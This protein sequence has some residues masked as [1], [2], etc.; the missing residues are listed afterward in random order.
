MSER[1]L[2]TGGAGFFGQLL[3]ARLLEAGFEVRSLDVV[4]LEPSSPVAEHM[5]E[6]TGDVRDRAAVEQAVAGCEVVVTN[7]AL[8]PVTRAG[9]DFESVNVGGTRVVLE[10]ARRA[11][12]RHATHISSSAV[13]GF[14]SPMPI[15]EATPLA[16]GERYGRSKAAAEQAAAESCGGELPLAI[17]RPRTLVGLGRLGLFEPLFNWVARS[18]PV[19]LIGA[20]GNL[21]QFLDAADL[22]T[23]CLEGIRRKVAGD[24][25]LGSAVYGTL[26]EDIEAVIRHAGSA[27]R[28]RAVP[29]WAA[30]LVLQPLDWA[31]LSPFAPWHYL[32]MHRPFYFDI[33]KAEGE[34]GFQPARSDQEIFVEAYDWHISH[35]GV[36]GASAHR[37]PLRRGLLGLLE[38]RP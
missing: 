38:R 18:R 26:R 16:P 9:R 33:G 31:R 32:G 28:I 35:E 17:L 21:F 2:I 1:V 15:T 34:L 8:V 6:L 25:N 24:F 19:Y 23:A 30:R 5:E 20:G 22:A 36:T 14:R 10:A 4:P 7:H 12:A 37:R 3:A 11:G 27:S 13:Y 29:P